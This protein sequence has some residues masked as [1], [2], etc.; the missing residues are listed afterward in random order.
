MTLADAARQSTGGFTLQRNVTPM[1]N[2]PRLDEIMRLLA[3][4]Q[5]VKASD[6]AQLLFVSEETIRRDFKHLE[7]EGRLRR[8]HGGAILP[9]SSEELP[10][11]ERSRLKPRAKAGI[12]TCA[13][14]L[15]TEGMAIFLDTGTS[16]LALAQQLTRFSQLKII[17]NSLDIAQLISHQSDNQ[18]LVAPG[19]VRRTDN[20]L[21]GPHTLEF[22]RQ[23]HYDIA[24][25]GIGGI[26]LDLGL[27]DYQEPEAMLRRTLVRHC[28]RSVVLADDGKFGHR[29]FINTLP[30]AAITTLVTNRPLSDE[31][32]T[33]LEKDHVDTLCP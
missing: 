4:Q 11:Q 2:Q 31:F 32:A 27:M 23:F 14:Q 9:R 28:A 22:A 19:D 6:L 30:F 3:Q 5:R 17:T 26:D 24:F 13:A 1:L 7:E 33:R 16:T 15:V 8:I 10:L 29:T 25:M 12:A 20:A 21:I 18:V